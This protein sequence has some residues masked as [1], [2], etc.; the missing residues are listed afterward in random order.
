MGIKS[1]R[2]ITRAGAIAKIKDLR[3]MLYGKSDGFENWSNT[4]IE[5]YLEALNDKYYR[6]TYG[7]DSGFDNFLIEE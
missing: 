5:I 2:T 6:K 3:E 4:E 7:S 1:T